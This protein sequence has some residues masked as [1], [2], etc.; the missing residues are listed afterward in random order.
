MNIQEAID[1]FLLAQRGATTEQTQQWYARRLKPLTTLER[2]DIANVTT[3][4]LRRVWVRLLDQNRRWE[5]HPLRPPVEGKL[6]PF[7][8][9]GYRRAWRTLFRW[10]VLE[11]IIKKD[12]SVRLKRPEL[13][14]EL[15][16][17]IQ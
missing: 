14:E 8:L 12:P 17:A 9:D 2:D 5:N 3:G 16:K 1:E 6:S 10:C 15:P 7:T 4:D 13:P 11:E